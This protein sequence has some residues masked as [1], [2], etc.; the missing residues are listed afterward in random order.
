MIEGI[1]H[2]IID[3][4]VVAKVLILTKIMLKLWLKIILRRGFSIITSTNTATTHCAHYYFFYFNTRK[5]RW[6]STLLEFLIHANVFCLI[7]LLL[8]FFFTLFFH[9]CHCYSSTERLIILDPWVGATEQPVKSFDRKT[10]VISSQLRQIHDQ[11]TNVSLDFFFVLLL[12]QFPRM[13]Q[14]TYSF[15]ESFVIF[16]F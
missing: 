11:L 8:F 1:F 10:L 2:R 14:A 12:I 15:N 6:N 13:S 16:V 4:Y 7:Q 3:A 9:F 5:R